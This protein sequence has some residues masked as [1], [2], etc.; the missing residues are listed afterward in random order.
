MPEQVEYLHAAA[1]ERDGTE[2]FQILSIVGG[3]HM[4]QIAGNNSLR[5]R[6]DHGIEYEMV[7]VPAVRVDT[8]LADR[9]LTGLPCVMWVDV[10]GAQ[11]RVMAGAPV[12]LSNCVALMIEVEERAF[13]QGQPLAGDV[14]EAC[15]FPRRRAAS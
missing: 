8:L 14:H 13:W 6:P 10:E 1:C 2:E 3:A 7:S 12:A 11:D 4:P 5:Q 9:G 15:P